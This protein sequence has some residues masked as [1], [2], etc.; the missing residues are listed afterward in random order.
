MSP[1][2]EPIFKKIVCCFVHVIL[3]HLRRT[4]HFSLVR[5]ERSEEGLVTLAP[6]L[7]S[8]ESAGLILGRP[9]FVHFQLPCITKFRKAFTG[10]PRGKVDVVDAAWI[11]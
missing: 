3:F 1:C 11:S 4:S 9:T 5:P 8:A 2:L 6:F 7:V 10:E